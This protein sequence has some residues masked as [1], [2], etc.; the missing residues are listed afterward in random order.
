MSGTAGPP[1]P[2]GSPGPRNPPIDPQVPAP[3]TDSGVPGPPPDPGPPLPTDAPRLT[4]LGPGWYPDPA[5]GSEAFRWW[6]GQGWTAWLASDPDA[7]APPDAADPDAGPVVPPRPARRFGT[8]ARVGIGVL[9]LLL[10]VAAMVA[11]GYPNRSRVVFTEPLPSVTA[12][13]GDLALRCSEE[14]FT[15]GTVIGVRPTQRYE[16]A[17]PRDT[18]ALRNNQCIGRPGDDELPGNLVYTLGLPPDDLAELP[19]DQMAEQMVDQIAGILYTNGAAEIAERRSAPLQG[20]ADATGH[21]VTGRYVTTTGR[22]DAFEITVL[23]IDNTRGVWFHILGTTLDQ[24]DKDE[25]LA[26]RAT[27]GRP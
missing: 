24:A 1:D 11:A 9:V 23:E 19:V 26:V 25:V 27:L 6:T 17:G 20:I 14:R 16:I 4:D 8:P 3:P 2:A 18:F 13:P 21:T 10:V 12:T 22:S 7:A 5:R 15:I